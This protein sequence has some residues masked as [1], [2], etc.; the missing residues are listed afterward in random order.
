MP[1]AAEPVKTGLTFEE[2]LEFE[3]TSPEKHEFVDGQL[4]M[5][6]GG[7]DRHNRLAFLIAMRLEGESRAQSCRVY[8]LDMKIRTPDEVSYYPDVFVTCDESDD[9]TYIKQKPCL[10]LEVLSNSTEAVDRGEKL[11]NYAKLPSLQGYVLVSQSEPRLEMFRREETGWR[12]EVKEAGETLTLPC[13]GL[14]L[15]V[16]ELYAGL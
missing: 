4:F 13:L 9:G 2:Y 15:N 10:I 5:M 7:S 16:D 8:L 11:R 6:A 14:T 1:R 3:R 12:Y